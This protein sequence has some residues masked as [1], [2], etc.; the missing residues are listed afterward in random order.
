MTTG[1]AVGG[2]APVRHVCSSRHTD[3]AAPRWPRSRSSVA[4][5]AALVQPSSQRLT[6]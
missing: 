2:V 4:R 5:M 1:I 6:R 3:R